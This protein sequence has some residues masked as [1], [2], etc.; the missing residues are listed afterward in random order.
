MDVL[1]RERERPR[2]GRPLEQL[3]RRLVQARAL[4]VG[5][6]GGPVAGV[7]AEAPGEVGHER[8]EVRG[9]RGAGRRDVELLEREVADQL[10][11]EPERRAAALARRAAEVERRAR[12]GGGAVGAGALEQLE[13]EA[14]LAD[15]RVGRDRDD[16]APARARLVPRREQLGEL[17]LATDERQPARAGPDG[18]RRGRLGAQRVDGRPRRRGRGQPQLAPQ[19]L[20]QPLVDGDGG[21][22]LPGGGEPA[23]EPP[24]RL[25]VEAV[26]IGLAARPPERRLAVAGRLR[27]AGEALEHRAEPLAVR[28]ARLGDPVLLEALEQVAVAQRDGLLPAPGRDELL[29][30]A[31]VDPQRAVVLEA[32]PVA[33]GRDHGAGRPERAAQR[34]HGGA[35][36]RAG[37][38]VEDVRPEA[39]RDVRAGVAAGME[40]EP[41]QERGRPAAAGGVDRAAVGLDAQRPEHVDPEHAPDPPRRRAPR[42]GRFPEQRRR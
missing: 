10:G 30:R 5:R 7:G 33:V 3:D 14:G 27:V 35:Q 9:P 21:G 4:E 23:H 34:P 26:E 15:A 13:D 36:A 28:R 38:R 39:R 24:V 37:A 18:R 6:R 16:G 32:D 22:P 17:P 1:E 20:G 2:A 25:L 42:Q 29:E 19:A 12:R 31:R 41:G 40:R 8:G 11:P